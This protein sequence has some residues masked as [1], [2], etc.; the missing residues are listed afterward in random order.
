[1]HLNAQIA[2]S[3]N[4]YSHFFHCDQKKILN[5]LAQTLFK[6]DELLPFFFLKSLI[7]FDKSMKIFWGKAYGYFGSMTR[8]LSHSKYLHT[9][10]VH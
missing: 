5:E 2:N 10:Q 9:L 7:F 3:G 6:K 1:M 4:N 8:R